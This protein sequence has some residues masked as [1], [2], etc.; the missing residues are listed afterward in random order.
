MGL[1]REHASG[2]Y[3]F[4]NMLS[5]ST[6]M[7]RIK[8]N[9]RVLTLIYDFV[10]YYLLVAVGVTYSRTITQKPTPE[11][12]SLMTIRCTAKTQRKTLWKYCVS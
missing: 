11:V 7:Y 10:S 1:Y 8:A 12:C 4:A 3:S 2:Y 6:M 9:A 5:V